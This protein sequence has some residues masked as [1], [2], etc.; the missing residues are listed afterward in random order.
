MSYS[1]SKSIM[2]VSAAK[3]AGKKRAGGG[4]RPA[5]ED[6]STYISSALSSARG[7]LGISE[8]ASAVKKAGYAT[9]SANFKGIVAM[10]LSTNKRFK[11]VARGSYTLGK[12]K[13]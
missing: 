10:R 2:S 5:G 3:K 1:T 12:G 7:P 4:R 13:K 8:I 9:S 6:L 11:R